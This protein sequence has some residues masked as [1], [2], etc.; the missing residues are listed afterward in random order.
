MACDELADWLEKEGG[1]AKEDTK[2][3]KGKCYDLYSPMSTCHSL[4]M[5]I[6]SINNLVPRL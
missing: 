1:V 6:T 3:L 2:K 5:M 4:I